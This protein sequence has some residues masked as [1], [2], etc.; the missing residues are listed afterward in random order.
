MHVNGE[1]QLTGRNVEVVQEVTANT[2]TQALDFNIQ[3]LALLINDSSTES[4]LFCFDNASWKTLK[5]GEYL[6]DITV[7]ATTI[8]VKTN[9]NTAAFRAWGWK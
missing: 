5:P 3:H 8:N 7:M 6:S 2:T 4:L 9:A 1:V